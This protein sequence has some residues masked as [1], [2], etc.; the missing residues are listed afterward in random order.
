MCA[1]GLSL[2]CLSHKG[3]PSP[4]PCRCCSVRNVI[5]TPQRRFPAAPRPRERL[6]PGRVLQHSQGVRVAVH[7]VVA[8]V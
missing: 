8:D 1:W 4:R 6:P 7:V 2:P 5:E 3:A